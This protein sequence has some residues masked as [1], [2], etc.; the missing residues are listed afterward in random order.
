MFCFFAVLVS[1][2]RAVSEA[3]LPSKADANHWG[4]Y[5]DEL[6]HAVEELLPR[7][8]LNAEEGDKDKGSNQSSEDELEFGT[9]TQDKG[10]CGHQNPAEAAQLGE[11]A[12]DSCSFARV[13]Q[14]LTSQLHLHP[15][16]HAL[17]LLAHWIEGLLS[18]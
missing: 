15:I 14:C 5:L 10:E 16:E 9:R 12:Q 6:S 1:D 7:D 4:K 3:G 13:C 17:A 18:D 11:D 2:M 8:R